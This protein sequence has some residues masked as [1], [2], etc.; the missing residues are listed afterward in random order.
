VVEVIWAKYG[1]SEAHRK[2]IRDVVETFSRG[3]GKTEISRPR[4]GRTYSGATAQYQC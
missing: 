1:S 4:Q 3:R 2:K